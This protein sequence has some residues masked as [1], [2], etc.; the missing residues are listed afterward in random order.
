MTETAASTEIPNQDIC[1]YPV[2]WDDYPPTEDQ[3]RPLPARRDVAVVGGGISGLS[4]ALELA[5][6]GATVAVLEA[7]TFGFN[8]STRNSGGVSFGLDLAKIARW[9][10]WSGRRGPD[11][12]ALARGAL[13]SF[14]YTEGFIAD[15]AIDCDYHRR[16]RLSCAATPRHFDH[17]SRRAE[18]LNRLFDAGAYMVSR[19][20]QRSE[21]GSDRFYGTMVIERSG[22]LD[23]ARYLHALTRLCDE[24]GVS[25]HSRTLVE[26]IDR[27][28]PDFRLSTAAGPLSSS[29]VVVA[30]NAHSARLPCSGLGQRIVPVASHIIVT[31]PLPPELAERLIPK[32]RTGADNRRMLAYFRRMPDGA[33]FLYGSR[34]A[35]FDVSPERAAA[36]LYRRMV[37]S[38]PDLSGVRIS[39]AWGCKVAFTLD[40]I[41]HMGEIGGLHYIAGCNGNGVAM[42]TY[43]GNKVARKILEGGKPA[44]VFDQVAFPKLPLYDGRP[45]F[46]PAVA[47]GYRTLDYLDSLRA[48]WSRSQ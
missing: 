23:P 44:C 28:G 43:L 30:T 27:V 2:W 17:L 18:T 31:D 19:A 5:R 40:S 13:E 35:P 48:K 46:L 34:A 11:I 39:H 9:S 12:A 22:Q 7:D 45:W 15:N 29:S 16:G 36:V 33:R 6:S 41:P 14:T 3:S 42:M 47:A 37:A 10:R 32:R 25:R 38:F 24:A 26:R 8:A 20:E 4:A 1:S 21:I